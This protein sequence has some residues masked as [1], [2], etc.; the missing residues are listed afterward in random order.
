M[1]G[2][3]AAGGRSC[4]LSSRR[5]PQSFLSRI[6]GRS[7]ATWLF[8]GIFSVGVAGLLTRRLTE[9]LD[10]SFSTHNQKEVTAEWQGWAPL[11][12]GARL[13]LLR[14]AGSL[15][16]RPPPASRG[17]GLRARPT[18]A[19]GLPSQ[20]RPPPLAR[21]LY[22]S[23]RRRSRRFLHTPVRR[24]RLHPPDRP[25]ASALEPT[26]PERWRPSRRSV[27]A[28]PGHDAGAGRGG[29]HRPPRRWARS[30]WTA[31]GLQLQP[32]GSRSDPR[33]QALRRPQGTC[34]GA[35]PQ[36]SRAPPGPGRLPGPAARRCSARPPAR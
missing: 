23:G 35:P 19:G 2:A 31:R 18:R 36:F 11:L 28:P 9:Q 15:G 4:C 3:T 34:R 7:T 30:S 16:A 24:R 20:T 33:G 1:D 12:G 6:A 22:S 29:S 32:L 27:L 13:F 8:L 10:H 21:T 5:C 25:G 26:A 14:Q 17:R